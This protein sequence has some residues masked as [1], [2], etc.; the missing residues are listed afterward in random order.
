MADAFDEDDVFVF[1]DVAGVVGEITAG[2]ANA[3]VF[4]EIRFSEYLAFGR[5]VGCE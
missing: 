4:L 3:L 1:L 5:A 2:D